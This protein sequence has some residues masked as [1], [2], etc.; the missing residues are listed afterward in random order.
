MKYLMAA[1]VLLLFVPLASADSSV[2]SL[3]PFDGVEYHDQLIDPR[4]GYIDF[5][6]SFNGQIY[7]FEEA[8]PA[9]LEPY[10]VEVDFLFTP[11]S[12]NPAA[13]DLYGMIQFEH[14]H[15]DLPNPE[16]RQVVPTPEPS[17]AE[18]MLLSFTGFGMYWAGK[19]LRR[20][21]A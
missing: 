19:R 7:L 5:P 9:F 2:N 15:L 12:F 17:S 13:N 16:W 4:P 6:I 11:V 3:L 20:V 18:L 21:P 10:L 1:L 14:I 8:F